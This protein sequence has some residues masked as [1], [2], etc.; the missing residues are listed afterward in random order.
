[1]MGGQ[2]GVAGHLIIAD[3]TKIAAQSGIGGNIKEEGTVVQG[4]PA[5]Y[6]GDY[7]R[8]YVGFKKLPEI[9]DRLNKLEKN[10]QK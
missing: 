2:V 6:I 8:A 4:S 3:G 5:F 1:M 10:N 9:L 7:K